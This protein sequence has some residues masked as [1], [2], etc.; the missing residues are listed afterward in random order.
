MKK[1]ITTH[2]KL[3]SPVTMKNTLVNFK[4]F[5]SLSLVRLA[6]L[7]ASLKAETKKDLFRLNHLRFSRKAKCLTVVAIVAVLLLSLFAFFP[8]QSV[9]K[10]NV[11]PQSA[12]NSTATPSPNAPANEGNESSI[13]NYGQLI[14]NIAADEEQTLADSFPHA[15]GLI[16]SAQT[17]NSTVWMKV[18][19]YAWAYFQPSV[20]VNA[21]TGLPLADSECA[22]FY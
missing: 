18:A 21:N 22:R 14:G 19:A 1:G 3:Y 11:T 2:L 10:A 17:I 4:K 20:G 8:K 13:S 6:S 15:P 7:E 9:S 12:D 5:C 16:E